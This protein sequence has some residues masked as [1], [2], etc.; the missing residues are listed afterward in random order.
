MDVNDGTKS[1]NGGPKDYPIGYQKPPAATRF[2]KGQSGNPRGRPRSKSLEG[3]LCEALSRRSAYVSPD[4]SAMTCA[5]SI[6]AG[7]V[8]AAEGTDLKPKQLLFDVLTKLHRADVAWLSH[9]VPE[10]EV[11]EHDTDPQEETAAPVN[12]PAAE[13]EAEEDEE[14]WLAAEE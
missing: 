4:G 11:G 13:Q 3:L 12:G 7:L 5:E 1:M 2:Q 10:I 8:G 6:F 9:R 14:A